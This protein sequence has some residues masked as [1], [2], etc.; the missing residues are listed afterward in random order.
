MPD[1]E[2]APDVYA[3]QFLISSGVWGVAMSFLKTPPHPTPGQTP[4]SERQATVRMS[5][6]HAKVIA[7][8]LRKQLKTWERETNVDIVIPNNVLNQLGLSQ[9]D[10]GTIASE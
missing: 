9:E 4:Q 8:M 10:W 3:D 2:N 6:Q 1:D 5:L 7:M